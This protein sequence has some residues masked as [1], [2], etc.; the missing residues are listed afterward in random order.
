VDPELSESGLATLLGKDLDL[1]LIVGADHPCQL[2]VPDLALVTEGTDV[3]IGSPE[4]NAHNALAMY[5]GVRTPVVL[6][7][8]ICSLNSLPDKIGTAL[9]TSLKIGPRLIG[10]KPQEA[11]KTLDRRRRAAQ[12]IPALLCAQHRCMPPFAFSILVRSSH[13]RPDCQ[14]TTCLMQSSKMISNIISGDRR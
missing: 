6:L 1:F 13:S 7:G 3:G 14:R 12:I 8:A 10:N 11:R 4:H 5:E 9:K 2:I